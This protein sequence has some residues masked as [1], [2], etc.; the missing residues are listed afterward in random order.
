MTVRVLLADDQSLFREGLRALLGRL[1]VPNLVVVAD[2]ETTHDTLC[3]VRRHMP[4]LLVLDL[5]MPGGQP[6]D[7]VRTLGTE[8]PAL[9]ILVLTMYDDPAFLR[10]VLAAGAHGYLLK[11]SA[12]SAFAEAVHAV[13]RG[14]LFVD[15]SLRL[16]ITIPPHSP[17]RAVDALTPRERDVLK[18]LARGLTYSDVGRKLSIG[19]RT[20]ETHRR[21]V[22]DKLGLESRA[23]LLRVAL[24]SGLLTLGDAEELEH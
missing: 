20:V 10:S 3:Q 17:A 9:K 14:S 15:R 12:Y 13:L 24:E 23:D 22:V 6:I 1:E 19:A 8:H 18:L 11:R 7:L 4:D 5:K 2:A 16:D 21:K